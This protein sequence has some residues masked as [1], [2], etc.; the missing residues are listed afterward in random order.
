MI[1]NLIPGY[2]TKDWKRE[3]IVLACA[4]YTEGH[5]SCEIAEWILVRLWIYLYVLQLS[6]LHRTNLEK[7]G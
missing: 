2:V 5:T 3:A 4:P 6:C 1:L 7:K